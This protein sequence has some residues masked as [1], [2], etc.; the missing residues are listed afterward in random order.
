MATLLAER[1]GFARSYCC[2]TGWG[3]NSPKYGTALNCGSHRISVFTRLIYGLRAQSGEFGEMSLDG[4]VGYCFRAD[5]R[6]MNCWRAGH[7]AGWWRGYCTALSAGSEPSGDNL[8]I[9][10]F[11]AQEGWRI[12][13]RCWAAFSISWRPIFSV[14]LSV[15]T[16]L[17]H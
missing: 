4:D 6:K 14:L 7:W 17:R 2:Y 1:T 5:A 3:L 12:N 16:A 13:R 8:F 9:A 10:V 15:F 11:G